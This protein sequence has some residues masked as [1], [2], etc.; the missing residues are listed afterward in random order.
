M[1]PDLVPA[2]H[3]ERRGRHEAHDSIL[4]TLMVGVLAPPAALAH[5]DGPHK[6]KT[7]SGTGTC[8]G[9]LAR[10][11]VDAA[12]VRSEGNVPPEFRFVREATGATDLQVGGFF[13][14]ESTTDGV[15]TGA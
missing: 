13:C 3:S 14:S 8:E 11:P 9:F 7:F 15:V 5:E 1:L 6:E 4:L 12:T 10:M 2:N